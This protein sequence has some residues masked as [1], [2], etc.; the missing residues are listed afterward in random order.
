MGN[1]QTG[2]HKTTSQPP[3][4]KPVRQVTPNIPHPYL[5][6]DQ[7]HIDTT[8]NMNGT[9]TCRRSRCSKT[10][11]ECV[12][13]SA[14][15]HPFQFRFDNTTYKVHRFINSGAHAHA[16]LGHEILNA[17]TTEEQQSSNG[18]NTTRTELGRSFCI[19]FFLREEGRG[20]ELK[21]LDLLQN[22]PY[23]KDT[24]TPYVVDVLGFTD[25]PLQHGD[26]SS[27]TSPTSSLSPPSYTSPGKFGFV[28][29]ELGHMGEILDYIY[30]K[31]RLSTFPEPAARRMFKQM[32]LGLKYMH[33][34]GVWH[35]DLKPEN[36]VFDCNGN[37]Q[38]IDFGLV[39]SVVPLTER[40]E[41][42]PLQTSI[43]GTSRVG[44]PS[45]MSPEIKRGKNYNEKT[46]VWSAGCSLLVLICGKLP[47]TTFWSDAANFS[48]VLHFMGNNRAWSED[49]IAML[50]TVFAIDHHDRASV[51]EL[52]QCAWLTNNHVLTDEEMSAFLVERNVRRVK[53]G[54]DWAPKHSDALL[55][56]IFYAQL[57]GKVQRVSNIE[58]KHGGEGEED[59]G[60]APGKELMANL[61]LSRYVQTF[62]DNFTIE[63]LAMIAEDM[64]TTDRTLMAHAL[65]AAGYDFA[66]EWLEE[67]EVAADS[68]VV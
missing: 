27:T 29:M 55:N 4:L 19:K 18:S 41:E 47:P 42:N 38:L 28:I 16:F 23:H 60:P 63:D 40:L 26:M 68:I 10:G 50:K 17:S 59:P 32:L 46:D 57:V 7:L 64:N 13:L 12:G 51:D 8:K 39:K 20:G 14:Y 11:M 22:N 58:R 62:P 21:K 49:L 43:S 30:V 65:V 5:I 24:S 54:I 1:T 25:C 33:E 34:E 53:K 52:L 45:Y 67:E 35:R 31:K 6:A 66:T 15:T 48:Y 56:S 61:G 36:M 9:C 37:L 2:E 44:S 3:P